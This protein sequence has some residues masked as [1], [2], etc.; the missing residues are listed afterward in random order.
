MLKKFPTI[1]FLVITLF[2]QSLNLKAQ[3]EVI[4]SEFMAINTETITDQ[5]EKYSDWI[6][7]YNT[8][9][10]TINM[11]GFHLTDDSTSLSKWTFPN[12]NLEPKQYLIVFA[13]GDDIAFADE[14]LHTNFKLSGSGEFLALLNPD[15]TVAT[16][17]SP[18]YPY[19]E[20]DIS[21]GNVNGTYTKLY[22]PTPGKENNIGTVTPLVEFSKQR[23][24][25]TNKFTLELS[26][27]NNAEIYYTTNGIIPNKVTGTKYTSPIEISV[28]TPVSAVAI[29]E[30]G[31]IGQV[32]SHTY[33]F[34]K[35]VLTQPNSIEGYPDNWGKSYLYDAQPV[36]ADYEM[37]PEICNN[38]EYTSDLVNGLQEIPTF[39][40]VTNPDHLFLI[41]YTEGEQ[42]GI[43]I[44]TGSSAYKSTGAD[45]EHPASA[46]Y[47]D[48]SSGQTFQIN[49]SLKLHGGNSR[50]PDNS[51]KHSFR[52]TFSS[53]YGPSKLNFKLFKPD[54]NPVDEFNTLVLRAG[55]NYSWV[56]NSVEQNTHSDY[57]RDAFAKRTQLDLGSPSA[58][59]RFVH[60]YLNGIYWGLY[61]LSEKITDD[62][63]ETH[64]NGQE[65][66]WDVVEDHNSV[67]DGSRA[68]FN[69]MMNFVN[70]GLSDNGK[71][72]RLQGLNIDGTENPS[73]PNYLDV[74]NFIDYMI[75]NFYIGN[76][77]WDKNN[78]RAGRNRVETKNG[79]RFFLWDSETSMLDINEN[80]TSKVDGEPTTIWNKLSENKEFRLKVADHLQEHF[81]N[82]GALTVNQTTDRYEKLTQEI[83]L[84]I[85]GESA[86]WGDY[87]RDA[88]A[89]NGAELYTKN[90]HWIPEIENQLNNYLV[91]RSSI[92]FEQLRNKGL[93]P[94]LEAPI[95]SNYSETIETSI[96]FNIENPN[97]SGTIYYTTDGSDPRLF[98]GEINSTAKIFDKTITL[99]G[100][101]KIE[102]RI[103]DGTTWSAKTDTKF[104]GD[105]TNFIASTQRIAFTSVK[106]YPNP[107]STYT[108]FI[109]KLEQSGTVEITIKSVDG[110]TISKLINEHQTPGIKNIYFETIQFAS[111]VYL[112]EINANGLRKS[113]KLVIK[114]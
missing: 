103:K 19:Q 70:N 21:Y 79:F 39:S 106:C 99:V 111:G 52:L 38:E 57:L 11:L 35:S 22:T 84:A 110:K 89:I 81:F 96:E 77:D 50:K 98:G 54:R 82:N 33:I 90:D 47:L 107:A 86:R 28:S 85:I 36:I 16:K 95:F 5:N 7:I 46:E 44:Y 6:E 63:M 30:D 48:P 102:A 15:L 55:Y 20:A 101:G 58:H 65:A 114:P 74:D 13:S 94:T 40:I 27:A 78:W 61:D 100:K 91:E 80:I 45:W 49:C 71:Y 60:L 88:H 2:A 9:N 24:I 83:D 56:K 1:F 66:D 59:N 105:T 3:T 29:A 31:S 10:E 68:T 18:V 4:I 67:I 92:V 64:M 53:D 108:N 62:F 14:E 73:Y 112:Y 32:V 12:I 113:D 97:S 8:G 43:Y 51:P 25:Y 87:R 42:G 41:D 75:A 69:N 34:P 104:K 72:M 23:G 93:Y 37:D 17:F 76:L 26:T 109:Y